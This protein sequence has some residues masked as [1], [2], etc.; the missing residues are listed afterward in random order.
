GIMAGA[1]R[2]S[3]IW[4][5]SKAFGLIAL[6]SVGWSASDVLFKKYAVAFESYHSALIIYLLGSFLP[7]LV[8]LLFISIRRPLKKHL[9]SISSRGWVMVGIN[10]LVGI[11][12]T[13]AFSYALTLGKASLTSVFLGIQPLFAFSWGLLLKKLLHEVDSEDLS[14]Q[15]LAL[16]GASLLLVILGLSFL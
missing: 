2:L 6:T 12:G 4:S 10:L 3:G 9:A 13:I 11:G 5:V 1:K 14:T 7:A 15:T 16:K 8:A